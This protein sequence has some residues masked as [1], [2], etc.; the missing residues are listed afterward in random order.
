MRAAKRLLGT[1][2]ALVLLGASARGSETL[3]VLTDGEPVVVEVPS[4]SGV[5]RGVVEVPEGAVALGIV[6]SAEHDVDLYLEF[7]RALE[8]SFEGEA[9]WAS[10]GEGNTEVVRLTPDDEPA[11]RPGRWIVHVVATGG[12]AKQVEVVAYVDLP[13]GPRTLLPDM[14]DEEDLPLQG[15]GPHF[16][17]FLPR[18]ATALEVRFEGVGEDRLRYAVEGPR[19]HL[20]G[21]RALERLVVP[22]DEG[23]PGT[24]R[25]AFT[26]EAGDLPASVRAQ[27]TWRLDGEAERRD[28][29][30]PIVRPGSSLTLLLGQPQDGGARMV[31]IPVARGTGGFIVEATTEPDADV[32]LY[33]RRGRPLRL[34]DRDADYFA[35]TCSHQERVI[36]GGARPLAEGTYY[37]EIVLVDST[38]PRRVRLRV[39]SYR[40]A[41]GRGSWGEREPQ[42][43][44]PGGFERGRVASCLAGL[45]WYAVTVPAGTRSL[46]AILVDSTAPLDLV[47]ARRTDGSIMQ[48]ALTARVDE[49]LDVTFRPP[50]DGPR[51]FLL[52]VMNRNPSEQVVDFRV[53][54]GFDRPPD[55]PADLHWPPVMDVT[56]AS[57]CLRAAAA[58]VELTIQGNAG[59]SGTCVS[60]R[61]HV[62]TCRHVLELEEEGGPIQ[63]EAIL[64]AF[65]TRIDA[66]PVQSYL[67]RVVA[68]DRER[69]LALLELVEDVFGRAVPPTVRLPFLPLGAA[70]DLGIGERVIVLGYPSEGSEHSRTPV[71]VTQGT[72]A[73]FE[74]RGGERTWIKT[75]AWIGLGHS[76]GTLVD[77]RYRLVGVP[78]A[79]L[80]PNEALGLAVP[81]DRVPAP[82]RRIL[83]DAGAP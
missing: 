42:A 66:V 29:E 36:V 67:A 40:W 16:R 30:V 2:L 60:P 6:A 50:P 41:E 3:P 68:E 73:G 70:R 23:P 22:R 11:L 69:D 34:G 80:G 7:D 56:D 15:P 17:T 57:P 71:I 20:R 18:R 79:T 1:F 62:L 48:R 59:G 83:A 33:V 49:R 35:L 28:E 74:S 14:Q 26:A 52:G 25:V 81:V 19:D 47:L 61:G 38:R 9:D 75:D 5:W 43:L 13:D 4:E 39:R 32:D 44:A 64:V 12:R 45:K 77:D 58:T 24:W 37:C 10:R 8:S 78:A 21:G 27:V 51:H 46:H 72:V 76:G 31:R 63:R 55:L 65:P 53:A 54:L 82:W